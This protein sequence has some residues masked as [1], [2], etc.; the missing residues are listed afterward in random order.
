MSAEFEIRPMRPED[1]AGKGL[2]H[3]L[4]WHETYRGLM[5]D[6][7]LDTRTPELCAELARS[8]PVDTLVALR[9]GEIVGFVCYCREAREFTARRGCSEVAA[10]YVLR[11]C[12]GLGLGRALME[13]ALER[14]PHRRVV[15]YV[16]RGNGH[17]AG[18]YGHLGF[19]PTGREYTD[20]VP[21]GTITELEFMLER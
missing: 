5:P 12:Q 9:G 16:L 18:F 10:L 7:F 2:V 1:C 13:A 11:R 8:R 14:L 20:T 3:S 4:A 15:L 6:E 17:A 21:G 19:A